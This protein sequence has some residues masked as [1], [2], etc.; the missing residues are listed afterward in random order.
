MK[1]VS[2]NKID[3]LF[4]NELF[5]FE[6]EAP[7]GLFDQIKPGIEKKS[8]INP[9]IMR[10]AAAILILIVAIFFFL[11]NKEKAVEIAVTQQDS[12]TNQHKKEL[13]GSETELEISNPVAQ[14]AEIDLKTQENKN[15]NSS[16]LAT[17]KPKEQ[18]DKGYKK[19]EIEN[20]DLILP[21]DNNLKN[22]KQKPQEVEIPKVII[23]VPYNEEM[24][25]AYKDSKPTE[26]QIKADANAVLANNTESLK[27]QLVKKAAKFISKKTPAQIEIDTDTT[28]NNQE[29]LVYRMALGGLS[30][31]GSKKIQ[32]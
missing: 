8:G 10:V 28:Q 14:N 13:N 19:T 20:H 30:F 12:T 6:M 27:F 23:P 25:V 29:K 9:W 31:S 2:E 4:Q 3:Q 16:S 26:E 7:A 21:N 22:I 17:N 5:D 24:P 18:I 11:P 32:P 15:S 1:K